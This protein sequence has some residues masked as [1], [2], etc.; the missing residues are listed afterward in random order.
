MIVRLFAIGAAGDTLA[1]EERVIAQRYEWHP[2]VRKLSD[3]RLAPG[4]ALP[5]TL[6][7]RM[8]RGAYRLVAVALNERISDANAD[9]HKLSRA[10]PRRVEVARVVVKGGA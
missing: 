3:N 6:K 2:R 7:F 4:E 8:P 1:R 5:V 9:F 10:Y